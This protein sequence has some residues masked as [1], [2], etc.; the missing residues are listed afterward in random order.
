MT[1]LTGKFSGIDK[2]GQN[3]L[4]NQL[5]SNIKSFLDWGFLNA[6]GFNNVY[7]NTKN[8]NNNALYKCYLVEDPNYNN[9]QVWQTPR[10]DWVYETGITT[11]DNLSPISISGIYINNTFYNINTSGTYAYTLDYENSRIIFNNKISTNANISMNYSYRWAQ[12]YNYAD[13]E[14]WQ[15]IQ[16][17]TDSNVTHMTEKNQGD[18]AINPKHRVQLPA[19]V[20]ETV[21]RGTAKPF[22]IGNQSLII[23]QD[24]LLHILAE[25]IFDRNNITDILRLQQDRVLV[26]YDINKVVN[27]GVYPIGF[28][29]ALNS[30]R[31]Q[32]NQ[33][34]NNTEYVWNTCRLKN[35]V[36]S[37]VE[38]LNSE[39][40]ECNIRVTAEIIFDTL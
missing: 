7:I 3:L 28:N 8:I 21:A 2:V 5:E 16:Y 38:S 19:I 35:M 33:L 20:I 9:G 29:G 23:E 13:A 34:I 24:F 30:S 18:F 37:E 4:N 31:L 27:S 39:L 1:Q 6:G 11:I 40:F 17:S 32:Y 12:I 22:K 15:E 10:K 36:L 26:F 25:N 14:W